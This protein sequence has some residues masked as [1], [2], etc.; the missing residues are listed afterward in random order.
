MPL[1]VLKNVQ[2]CGKE[3]FVSRD[4]LQ[5]NIF[6]QIILI[7]VKSKVKSPVAYQAIRHLNKLW[8]RQ[9]CYLYPHL[10]LLVLILL[11]STATQNESDNK[12]TTDKKRKESK[13]IYF[14]ACAQSL[15]EKNVNSCGQVILSSC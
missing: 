13:S 8:F 5:L 4:N 12:I 2:N 9:S 15:E 7:S 6:F 14:N 3:C 10:F 11:L 1:K